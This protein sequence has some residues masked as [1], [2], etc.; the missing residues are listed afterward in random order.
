MGRFLCYCLYGFGV[1]VLIISFMFATDELDFVPDEFKV[2]MGQERC[3]IRKEGAQLIELLYVYIPMA[4]VLIFNS[5]FYIITA[6]KIYRVQ[7][8]ASISRKADRI[9]RAKINRERD[10]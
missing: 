4:M 2:K 1:P 6:C 8:D 7:N 3:W 5:I 9:S 10:R